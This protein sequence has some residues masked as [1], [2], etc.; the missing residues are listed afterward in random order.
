MPKGEKRARDRKNPR[1]RE[2]HDQE[3]KARNAARG[4]QRWIGGETVKEGGHWERP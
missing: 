1:S 2:I 4:K 3:R